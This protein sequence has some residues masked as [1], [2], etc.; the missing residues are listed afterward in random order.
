MNKP[1]DLKELMIDQAQLAKRLREET[2]GEVMT[3]S[4]SRVVTRR[5][6]LSI[7]LCQ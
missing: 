6:P 1:L 2:S 5:M 4:A 3:D 7:K